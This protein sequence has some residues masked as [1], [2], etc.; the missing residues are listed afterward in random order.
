M[1]MC[2]H[3]RRKKLNLRLQDLR[4]GSQHRKLVHRHAKNPDHLNYKWP[5]QLHQNS[6]ELDH[7]ND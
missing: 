5:E 3:I 2:E 4:R 7:R 6:K 1:I